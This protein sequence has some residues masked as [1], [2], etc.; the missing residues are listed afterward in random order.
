MLCYNILYGNRNL[1]TT[2]LAPQ[3]P[4]SKQHRWRIRWWLRFF[5]LI[6]RN[7]WQVVANYREPIIVRYVK[8]FQ[9]SRLT[10]RGWPAYSW[11]GVAPRAYHLSSCLLHIQLVYT[12]LTSSENWESIHPLC[13]MR[14]TVMNH[15]RPNLGWR[16]V[17]LL[18]SSLKKK[19][20]CNLPTA[21]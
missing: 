12:R 2:L 8:Y 17:S 18:I 9:S 16:S 13:T 7:N 20:Q 6:H 11:A 3:Q 5:A 19:P 14:R 10:P 15:H 4:R 21:R 1:T